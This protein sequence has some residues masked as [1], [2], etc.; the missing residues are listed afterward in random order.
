[1]IP[2]DIE[3][4]EAITSLRPGATWTE[5]NG[6]LEWNDLVCGYKLDESVIEYIDP[7]E[8]VLIPWGDVNWSNPSP[9]SEFP[10]C[11]IILPFESNIE[12]LAPKFGTP[13]CTG[14]GSISPT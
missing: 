3:R 10:I 4:M 2:I 12:I 11:L 1:M 8:S 9:G 5:T 7:F 13:C 6:K 14:G